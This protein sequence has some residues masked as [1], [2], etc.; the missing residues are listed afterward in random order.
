MAEK[1]KIK[2][3][4]WNR[5]SSISKKSGNGVGSGRDMSNIECFNCGDK[6]HEKRNCPKKAEERRGSSNNKKSGGSS[7]Y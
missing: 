2:D 7:D 4:K 1:R 6:G 3:V 5:L